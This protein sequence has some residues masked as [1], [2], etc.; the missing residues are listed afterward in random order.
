M[1]FTEEQ[2]AIRRARALAW[3]HANPDRVKQN[4]RLYYAKNRERLL[5]ESVKRQRQNQSGN[6]ARTRAWRIKFPWYD[7]MQGARQRCTNPKHPR[8]NRYGG[9]GIKFL[10]SKADMAFMWQRDNAANQ[11]GPS[12]DR[13]DNDGDY[14]LENCHF[15][16]GSDNARKRAFDQWL[17]R[18]E[19]Q[20]VILRKKT[21]PRSSQEAARVFLKGSANGKGQEA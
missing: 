14:T 20:G 13:I 17:K 6:L 9:R 18:K 3:N 12:I 5:A 15:I 16:T 21:P 10:L 2:K 4:A 1:P 19:A 11:I 8:W 7:I